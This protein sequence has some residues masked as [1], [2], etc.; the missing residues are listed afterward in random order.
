MKKTRSRKSR[1]TVPLK[2][3]IYYFFF[4]FA[5]NFCPPGSGSR[6][7]I[8][9]G[10]AALL[11]NFVQL[12]LGLVAFLAIMS[13][14]LAAIPGLYLPETAGKQYLFQSKRK[15]FANIL[16]FRQE[17]LFLFLIK[18]LGFNT[19]NWHLRPTLRSK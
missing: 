13:V 8:E 19:E 12:E 16:F 1:D 2:K 14:F 11:N 3:E 18:F 17:S 5:G 15:I 10:S 6:D 9:P 4:F 7:S